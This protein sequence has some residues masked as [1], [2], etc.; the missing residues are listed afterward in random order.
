MTPC[1]EIKEGG[2]IGIHLGSSLTFRKDAE[3][4]PMTTIPPKGFGI[5]RI[6]DD[7]GSTFFCDSGPGSKDP[8]PVES[9]S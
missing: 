7:V 9:I 5:D 6:S 8:S 2:S 1:A 4:S 3:F